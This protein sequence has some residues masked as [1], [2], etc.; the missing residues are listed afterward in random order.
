MEKDL[1]PH[2][3]VTPRPFRFRA[4]G[5]IIRAAGL[6]PWTASFVMLFVIA[7]MTLAMAEPGV[8]GLGDA[9]WILFQAVST[10]GFGDIAVNSIPG[11]AAVVLLSVY[12]IFY[13]ALITGAVVSFCQERMRASRDESV[14]RFIDQLE[15]LPE[16]SHEELVDLSQKVKRLDGRR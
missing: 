4:L 5:P 15:H 16:L 11:R 6:G 3:K 2:P 7:S 13:L 8:R 10:I 9:A 12:S 14:A 1:R